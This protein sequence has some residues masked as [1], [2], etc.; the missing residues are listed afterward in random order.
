[1]RKCVLLHSKATS[2]AAVRISAASVHKE[3]IVGN[4][5]RFAYH[6]KKTVEER[7]RVYIRTVEYED[8]DQVTRENFG[9]VVAAGLMKETLKRRLKL[10]RV[11]S[12]VLSRSDNG[13]ATRHGAQAG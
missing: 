2:E 10:P 7:G 3:C 1:M 12:R 13:S 5:G 11:L 8:V 9:R 4:T 6:W